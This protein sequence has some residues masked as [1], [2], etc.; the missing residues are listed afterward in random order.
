MLRIRSLVGIGEWTG[1]LPTACLQFCYLLEMPV[2]LYRPWRPSQNKCCVS[3]LMYFYT[4]FRRVS[5]AVQQSCHRWTGLCKILQHPLQLVLI[6]PWASCTVQNKPHLSSSLFL[7]RW[8][9]LHG[10]TLTGV[11]L[12]IFNKI[13][14]QTFIANISVKSA[15]KLSMPECFVGASFLLFWCIK[16]PEIWGAEFQHCVSCNIWTFS[17]K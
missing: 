9:M 10:D 3:R 5:W 12:Y 13:V 14:P 7:V 11:D 16:I 17:L 8:A 1:D 6:M 4:K 2:S 15:I